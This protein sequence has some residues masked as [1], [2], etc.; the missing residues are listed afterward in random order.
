M[1]LGSFSERVYIKSRVPKGSILGPFLYNFII[2][3]NPMTAA[4]S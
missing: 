1:L 3:D 2:V 4:L